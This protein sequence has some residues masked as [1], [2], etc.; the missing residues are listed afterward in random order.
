MALIIFLLGSAALD[1]AYGTV[2]IRIQ[3]EK[4]NPG[5]KAESKCVPC[6]DWV[7]L[8]LWP[9]LL[10]DSVTFRALAEVS[11]AEQWGKGSKVEALEVLSHI[12]SSSFTFFRG[13][14]SPEPV[15][16]D[17]LPYP[18]PSFSSEVKL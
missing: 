10:H 12:K 18:N 13:T 7:Q 6:K 8:Q 15:R 17:S 9:W 4:I 1:D 3:Y 14:V 5:N 16:W 11:S 2:V